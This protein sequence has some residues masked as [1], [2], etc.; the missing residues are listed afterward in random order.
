MADRRSR[1]DRHQVQLDYTFDRLLGIKLQQI[2]ELLVP[3]L[4]R[5]VGE[6]SKVMESG[7]AGR[8]DLRQGVFRQA[9]R[10]EHDR[11][12][13]G[14]ANRF[15]DYALPSVTKRLIADR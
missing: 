5:I 14:G 13:D 9:A 3:D 12:P 11:Q 6:R 15:P 4:V 8:G 1:R 2:Y 10:G 7:N